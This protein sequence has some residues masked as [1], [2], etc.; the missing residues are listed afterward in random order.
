MKARLGKTSEISQTNQSAFIWQ[1]NQTD[2]FT[3]AAKLLSLATSNVPGPQYLEVE[4]GRYR[5]VVAT[6]DEYPIDFIR[7][8]RDGR[9]PPKKI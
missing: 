5:T 9:P 6:K 7:A 3:V 2:A 8:V 1:I 4:H